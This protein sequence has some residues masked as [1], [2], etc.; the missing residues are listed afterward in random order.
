MEYVATYPND[1]ITFCTSVIILSAHSD[2]TY[3]NQSKVCSCIGTYISLSEDIPSNAINGPI[4]TLA[5]IMKHVMS[6]AAEAK[7]GSLFI[8][9]KTMVPLRQSLEEIRWSQPCSPI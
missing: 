3:L 5:Q 6:S 9:A 1:G 2:A 4:L 8:T 7:H